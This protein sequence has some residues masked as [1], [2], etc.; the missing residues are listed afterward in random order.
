[1]AFETIVIGDERL[2][3]FVEQPIEDAERANNGIL[4]SIALISAAAL[5]LAIGLIFYFSKKIIIP[6]EKLTRSVE[7]VRLGNYPEQLD[8]SGFGEIGRLATVFNDMVEAI[9]E[10][11]TAKLEFLSTVSHELR[12]P[13]TSIKGSL[14]LLAGGVL[15]ELPPKA[16]EMLTIATKNLDRLTH[17]VN[18][19]LDVEKLLSDNMAFD[20]QPVDLLAITQESVEENEGYAQSCGVEFRIAETSPR[21]SVR[22]DNMKLRQVIANLL[23]NAAKFSDEGKTVDISLTEHDNLARFSVTDYGPGISKDFQRKIFERFAQA[24]A[25][26]TRQQAG[27]GLGLYISKSIIES[28]G[29]TIGYETQEGV[30]TTF[31]FTLIVLE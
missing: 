20:F 18:V 15:G 6:I 8:T 26:D 5:M 14:G 19:I 24:D 7:S 23:S 17:L 25:S 22:G 30:G 11:N 10:A 1:M 2:K 21:V 13:L 12:T 3:V 9:Q 31:F 27:T 28:H 29:G 4:Y 16:Q